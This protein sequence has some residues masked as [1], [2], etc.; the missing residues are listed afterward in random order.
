MAPDASMSPDP[1]DT[2]ELTETFLC[3]GSDSEELFG[4]GQLWARPGGAT[5]SSH[6]IPALPIENSFVIESAR[7]RSAHL[8]VVVAAGM[9]LSAQVL[10]MSTPR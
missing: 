8:H 4:S 6:K 1:A 7:R 2:V 10:D 5:S 3:G 9:S